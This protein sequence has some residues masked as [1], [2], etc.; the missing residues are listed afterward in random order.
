MQKIEST[1]QSA[2]N[3]ELDLREIFGVF[4]K[5]FL[6]IAVSSITI[7]MSKSLISP[8]YTILDE[9]P[10]PTNITIFIIKYSKTT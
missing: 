3:E 10:S 7:F 8:L 1:D 2:I 6:D 5:Y 9:S 4:K